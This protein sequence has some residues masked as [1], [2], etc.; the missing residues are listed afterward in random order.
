[1]ATIA[2]QNLYSGVTAGAQLINRKGRLHNV[3]LTPAAAA[4][5]LTVYDNTSATGNPILTLQAPANGQSIIA[6]CDGYE[7]N[8]GLW[9]VIAGTGAQ[10]NAF[11]E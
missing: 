10:V 2:T 1:M 11:V 4:A 7:F 6:E 9:V 5:T 3:V 8:I